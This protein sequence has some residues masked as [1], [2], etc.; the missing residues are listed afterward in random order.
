MFEYEVSPQSLI[1]SINIYTFLIHAKEVRGMLGTGTAATEAKNS[2][3]SRAMTW[4]LM[5][6]ITKV[7]ETKFSRRKF[8]SWLARWIHVLTTLGLLK[9][10]DHELQASLGC[11]GSSRPEFVDMKNGHKWYLGIPFP[12]MYVFVSVRDRLKKNIKLNP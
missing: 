10:K 5:V 2:L 4:V 3:T 11:T 8:R 6:R 7:I 1:H 12:S 9:Q